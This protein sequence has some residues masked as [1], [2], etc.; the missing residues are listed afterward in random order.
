MLFIITG[1]YPAPSTRTM[2]KERL[3]GKTLSELIAV[4]KRLGLPGFAA[5][6][7]ADWLYR[8]EVDSIEAMT[9]LSKKYRELL[10]IMFS[11]FLPL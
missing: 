9:N 10:R 11:D 6:Q 1:D 2:Q 3:Y 8:K 5:K 7:I 4:T